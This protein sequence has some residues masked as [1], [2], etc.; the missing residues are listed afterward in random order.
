[1]ISCW[2]WG[3]YVPSSNVISSQERKL[4]ICVQVAADAR[5]MNFY[6]DKYIYGNDQVHI[7]HD[8]KRTLN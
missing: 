4:G 3:I 2:R 6:E 7:K 5:L 1:M 8:R